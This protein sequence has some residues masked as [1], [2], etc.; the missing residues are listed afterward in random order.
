[1]WFDTTIGSQWEV[2][3]VVA[4]GPY[5]ASFE[6]VG[7]KLR[8]VVRLWGALQG[9]PWCVGI[10]DVMSLGCCI[11]GRVVSTGHWELLQGDSLGMGNRTMSML[12]AVRFRR[13]V[14]VVV[15]VV[16][17]SA[18]GSTSQVL[19]SIASSSVRLVSRLL[20]ILGRRVGRRRSCVQGLPG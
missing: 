20:A 3:L 1:M 6:S 15:Y 13:R 8:V 19:V 18:G 14:C 17:L 7:H 11:G 4:L 10:L 16:V 12:L 5:L 2:V 9:F